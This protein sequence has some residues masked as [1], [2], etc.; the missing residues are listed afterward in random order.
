MLDSGRDKLELILAQLH[1]FEVERIE[2]SFRKD[3]KF[4][5]IQNVKNANK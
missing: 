4:E 3:L 1:I 5:N 2:D